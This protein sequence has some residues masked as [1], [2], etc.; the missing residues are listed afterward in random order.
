[1]QMGRFWRLAVAT[2]GSSQGH[3]ELNFHSFGRI[4]LEQPTIKS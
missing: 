1:M 2:S 3:P 4:G